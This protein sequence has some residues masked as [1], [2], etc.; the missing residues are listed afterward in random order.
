MDV[1]AR[2]EGS[3]AS[4]ESLRE[5]ALRE[6]SEL[7]EALKRAGMNKLGDRARAIQWLK[8]TATL[9]SPREA[10]SQQQS[11]P[12]DVNG[13]GGLLMTRMSAGRVESD[14][15]PLPC[16]VKARLVGCVLPSRKRFES[17]VREM[18]LGEGQLPRGLEKGIQLMCTGETA[19]FILRSDYAYGEE[20]LPPDV[21]PGASV[22]FEVELISW[23]APRKERSEMSEVEACAEATRLKACGTRAFG[24]NSWLEAGQ[25]FH[26]AAHLLLTDFDELRAPPGA[27][28]EARGLLTSCWL[29]EALCAL[30]REEWF[31]AERIC[32]E[33]LLRLADPLG[34]ERGAH[35]KA[36]Y[37]RGKALTAMSEF[38]RARRDLKEAARLD[39]SNRDVR[40]AWELVKQ[41]EVSQKGWQDEV[42]SKMTTKLLYREVN[43]G[44]RIRST[45]PK[46]WMDIS[47]EA[48]H[49]GRIVFEL[50]EDRAP[51]TAENF[52][53]LCTGEKGI[54][55]ISGRP[56]HYRGCCFHRAVNVD[57]G[58][59]E[60]LRECADG[61]GRN[62]EI[63]KGMFIHGGDI[64]NNDGSGG[65]SIYG[66]FFDDEECELRHTDPGL[67]SMA[68]TT[69]MRAKEA[70]ERV[71]KPNLNN[72]QFLITTMSQTTHLGGSNIMHFDGRHVIFARVVKGMEVVHRINKLPVDV[73]QHHKLTHPALISDCGQLSAEQGDDVGV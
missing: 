61:T 30:K 47:I 71:H 15:L 67:V 36:L 73:A 64:I 38:E 44:R 18:T 1:E 55:K 8:A 2:L 21:P 72:S 53:A 57:D 31:H 32:S 39:P 17:C 23:K 42:L 51:K 29:N 63:W 43:V 26:R 3:G 35:V 14:R 54:S 27:E 50:F 62:L 70:E 45:H 40:E 58:P 28:E 56:L 16:F 7:Q 13:D 19:R 52:R 59:V 69:P 22:E 20:G 5:L 11:E 25:H 24:V 10:P 65:E 68:G 34:K 46:V 12:V 66:E 49:V 6:S 48:R 41:R 37:R 9:G 60:L 33:L 4:V